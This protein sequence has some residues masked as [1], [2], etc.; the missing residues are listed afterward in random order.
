MFDYN[1]ARLILR[2]VLEL[3]ALDLGPARLPI[4]GDKKTLRS[5]AYS[6]GIALHFKRDNKTIRFSKEEMIREILLNRCKAWH[7]Q[8]D[9]PEDLLAPV[10]AIVRS[11]TLPQHERTF[12]T[13]PFEVRVSTRQQEATQQAMFRA[14]FRSVQTQTTS[15]ALPRSSTKATQTDENVFAPPSL[16]ASTPSRSI[17]APC[18]A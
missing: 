14:N 6:F 4:E 5:L 8:K 7:K 11:A 3:N 12:V 10:P 15:A 16:M 1:T 18:W 13:P 17:P 2:A 9:I